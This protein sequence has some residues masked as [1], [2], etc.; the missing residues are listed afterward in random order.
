MVIASAEPVFVD[1]NVLTRATIVAAPLHAE[2]QA[3]LV[4]LRREERDLWISN[5]VIREYV[6][7]ASRP[8][9]YS[10]PIPMTQILEQVKLFRATFH[11]AED[12]TRVLDQL[13]ILLSEIPAGGKQIHD[14]N[15]VATMLAN[16]INTLLTFNVADFDRFSGHIKVLK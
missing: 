3:A 7:N 5:Q 12:T 4:Q 1:T 8:Q 15:I 13:L 9:S 6:A 16:R 2:A 10:Q 14:A 11:V